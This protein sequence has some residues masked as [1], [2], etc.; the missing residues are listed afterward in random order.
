MLRRIVRAARAALARSARGSS[1]GS[2]DSV[3]FCN[4]LVDRIVPG[5]VDAT[6]ARAPRAGCSA[7]A[8][9]CSPPARPT[10]CL[11][12][13]A[14]TRCA[15]GS[16]LPAAIRASSIAPDIRPYRERKVRLLNGAHTIG[17]PGRAARRTRDGA[18]R[19]ARTS[20]SAVSFAAWCST[21][22]CRALDAP[23]A[24]AF[25]SEVLERFANPYIRH[26]LIDI[27][28]YGTTKMRVRVVPS[29]VEYR[30]ANGA[31][32]GVAR[33]RV[34]GVPR[35]HA[36]RDPASSARDAGLAVPE[37]S[38]GERVRATWDR[39]DLVVGRDPCAISPARVCADR[40]L[41]GAELADV[42]GFADAVAEHLMQH[43]AP[44]RSCRA[45]RAPHRNRTDMTNALPSADEALERLRDDA[46]RSRHR[47]RR[48]RRRRPTRARAGRRRS[49]LR[50]DHVPHATR[51]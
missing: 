29:I 30:R 42:P 34:R 51:G 19:R 38:E 32:A 5:A 48:S 33:V 23:G 15:T 12:S 16:A 40:A 14:T 25:A 47:D 11:P 7:I 46:R 20:A 17:R 2:I 36:R 37:D 18:R 3:M 9:I 39:V 21:R 10:R 45:R 43:S 22:S 31:V 1:A 44:G 27:T 13:R 4:T 41:W 26:A 8:T 24:E 50:R 49:C 28:L 35:V 6:E